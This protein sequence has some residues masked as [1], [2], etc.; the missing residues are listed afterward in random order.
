[1]GNLYVPEEFNESK[2]YPAI[3][4]C[5][6]AGGVKE[7]TA[8]TYAEQLAKQGYVTMAY[9]A[10]YQGESSGEP[11]QMENPY[12][13][14]EGLAAAPCKDCTRTPLRKNGMDMP[15]LESA[16]HQLLPMPGSCAHEGMDGVST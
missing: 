8:G 12:I 7:Q 16:Q 3:V 1:M 5:H 15:K 2:Q 9:D 13:R 10:S 6:P 11:R 4:I 14:T